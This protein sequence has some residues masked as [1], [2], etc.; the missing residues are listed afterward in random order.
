M[1]YILGFV[2]TFVWLRVSRET[3][4]QIVI[5]EDLCIAFMWPLLAVGLA[6]INRELVIS[7]FLVFFDLDR[8]EVDDLNLEDTIQSLNSFTPEELN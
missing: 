7:N 3:I 1:F 2:L 6:W 5:L 4:E 8:Y